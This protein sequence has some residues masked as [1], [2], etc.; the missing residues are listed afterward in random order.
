MKKDTPAGDG[1]TV[2]KLADG[3]NL[4][5][6]IIQFPKNKIV[7]MPV[8]PDEPEKLAKSNRRLADN[9]ISELTTDLVNELSIGYDLDVTTPSFQKDFSYAMEC[10]RAS[11][12]RS[13]DLDHPFHEYI[14]AN[15]KVASKEEL[16]GLKANNT[17]AEVESV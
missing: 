3:P 9:L 6:Q 12:Y 15:V 14:D 2:L 16:A 5:A 1:G 8:E 7:R 13:F 11:I 17:T 10:V 4:S